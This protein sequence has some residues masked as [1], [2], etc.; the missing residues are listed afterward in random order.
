[1]ERVAGL[2]PA[3]DQ[4]LQILFRMVALVED[5]SDVLE[6]L[7]QHAVALDQFLGDASESDGVRLVAGIDAG[8][9]WD[10]EVRTHQQGQAHHAQIRPLR[11]GM[12][13]L[14]QFRRRA[15][16]DEGIEVCAIEAQAADINPKALHKLPAQVRLDLADSSLI[17]RFHGV[18]E[19]LGTKLLAGKREP[20]PEG[21]LLI[22]VG[23]LGLA[24]GACQ[25]IQ[26][27][28]HEILTDTGPLP[29]LGNVPIDQ[30][31]ELEPLGQAPGRGQ[32]AELLDASLD[33]LTGLLL[34]TGEECVAGAEVG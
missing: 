17:D 9:E 7:S 24:A 11:F 29:P 28:E 16:I 25:A 14:S 18:P 26:S 13:S 6:I 5:Q 21:G 1:M 32:Q 4:P 3:G 19:T 12:S 8:E 15:A 33:G 2:P 23:H 22:P 34:E 31:D 10:V 20:A 27:G 30:G